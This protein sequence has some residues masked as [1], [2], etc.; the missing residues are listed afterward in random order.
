[1]TS[2]ES[3]QRRDFL[4]QLGLA[5]AAAL[6]S[7][8]T[9]LWG[10]EPIVHPTARADSCILLWMAGGMAAP[11]TLDP[12]AYLPYEDGLEVKNILSTFPSIDT[13]VDGVKISQGMENIAQVMD[14]GTLIRSAFQPDL[15]A[16][17]HSRHQ[18]HWHTGYVPPLTVAAPHLGAWMAKVLGP[19]NDVVPPFINIGI[20]GRK[21][22]EDVFD[23]QPILVR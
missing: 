20:D 21:G 3:I 6:S 14:R 19:K 11:D 15:G 1:M 17:L 9:Q 5:S 8:G 22:T 13:N 23:L 12:K 2:F 10:S 4:K 18:Y 7:P 16:I